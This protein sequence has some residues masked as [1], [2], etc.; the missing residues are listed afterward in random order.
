MPLYRLTP[1]GE[2]VEADSIRDERGT[3]ALIGTAL[4]MNRPRDVVVR[5]VPASVVVEV[6]DDG[7]EDEDSRGTYTAA[8][9][10]A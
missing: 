1:P 9:P 2:L 8:S 6:V 5:R 3:V 4:V 7:R 10:A